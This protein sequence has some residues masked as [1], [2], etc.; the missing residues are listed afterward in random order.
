MN[1]VLAAASALAGATPESERVA[2]AITRGYV[3]GALHGDGALEELGGALL[4]QS[5]VDGVL[6]VEVGV[7]GLRPHPHLLPQVAKRQARD[8][9]LPHQLPCRLEDLPAGG[10]TTFGSPVANR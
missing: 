1:P 10:L 3:V 7:Q 4:E 2:D 5:V 9:L 6:G 8:P